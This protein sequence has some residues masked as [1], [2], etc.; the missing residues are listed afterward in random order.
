M[1]QN[2][3]R[4]GPHG[5][6]IPYSCMDTI[7]V[8]RKSFKDV[9]GYKGG[10]LSE[11]LGLPVLRLVCNGSS[12]VML[13]GGVPGFGVFFGFVVR[14]FSRTLSASPPPP[15]LLSPVPP[16]PSNTCQPRYASHGRTRT[17]RRLEWTRCHHFL[18]VK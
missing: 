3:D 14:S 13:F 7:T 18:W 2:L 6:V 17:P 12:S 16:A 1:H 5:G 10:F 15:H 11:S 8:L 9:A 4:F